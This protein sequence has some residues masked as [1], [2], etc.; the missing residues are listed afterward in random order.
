MP[1]TVFGTQKN[2]DYITEVLLDDQINVKTNKYVGVSA[3][4]S[5]AHPW[6]D[7]SPVGQFSFLTTIFK[8]YV[9]FQLFVVVHRSLFSR[10]TVQNETKTPD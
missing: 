5:T 10:Q 6:L 7:M 8:C 1:V 3:T 4:V 9:I 2:K